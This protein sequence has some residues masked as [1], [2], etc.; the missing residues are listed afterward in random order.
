MR[1]ISKLF[2]C[3]CHIL[4]ITQS[5]LG[6][7]SSLVQSNEDTQGSTVRAFPSHLRLKIDVCELENVFRSMSANTI[8]NTKA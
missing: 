3:T 2:T 8:Q 5:S 4:E 7:L 1:H 6:Y